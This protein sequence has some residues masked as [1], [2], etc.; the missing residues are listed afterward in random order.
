[1]E[2]LEDEQLEQLP[3]P[4]LSRLL[5]P[6]MPKEEISFLTSGLWQRGQITFSARALTRA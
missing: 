3:D 4:P 5:F 6:P 1:V 2:Q